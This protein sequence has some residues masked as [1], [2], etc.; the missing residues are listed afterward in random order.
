MTLRAALAGLTLAIAA[1]FAAPPAF[2][3][4]LAVDLTLSY[5]PASE[6]P[7][8]PDF[9]GS[10]LTGSVE[11]GC[12]A[13][14]AAATPLCPPGPPVDIGRVVVGDSF[15]TRFL[16][17]GPCRDASV[18]TLFFT[19]G[20]AAAGFPAIAIPPG[21][22]DDGPPSVLPAVQFALFDANGLPAVQS[23]PIFAFDAPVQVGEWQT[24]ARFVDVPEP[25]VWGLMLL[26]FTMAGGR[27]RRAR[28]TAIA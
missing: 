21:P 14:G 12:L 16:P 28:A 7:P 11:F 4:V 1:L 10:V 6:P 9:K 25:A 19:F 15:T 13:V 3:A 8:D 24:A 27:L 2:A 22:P 18:C 26:G 20:G 5:F 17:P 23:G